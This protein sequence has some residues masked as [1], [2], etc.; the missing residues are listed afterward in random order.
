MTE[1]ESSS[2]ETNK[3]PDEK[4]TSQEK[5]LCNCTSGELLDLPCNNA[6]EELENGSGGDE[7]ESSASTEKSIGDTSE[8]PELNNPSCI[9]AGDFA[10]V[11]NCQLYYSCIPAEPSGDFIRVENKCP[12]RAVFSPILGRC[13]RDISS[14]ADSIECT[15]SGNFP[16]PNSNSSYYWC[17][18][19][20][21]GGFH[22]Y[23]IQCGP[24]EIFLP[25][26]AKCFID[27]M[28]LETFPFN[29]GAPFF[30][31][32]S[33]RDV[34]K[35]EW[36]LIKAQEKAEMKKLQMKEKFEKKLQE[37]I[38]K[39]L[40][41]DAKKQSADEGKQFVC[42]EEGNFPSAI[43]KDRYFVCVSKK[44]KFKAIAMN[45]PM[46]NEYDME[47]KACTLANTSNQSVG[48]KK[49]DDS[50]DDDD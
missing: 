40:L 15:V 48:A 46:G 43:S 8:T 9:Q 13:T 24:S 1:S 19:N 2:T 27:F 16:D 5:C 36:K 3:I 18:E 32:Q 42:V 20:L 50:D 34:V 17:V 44:G 29:F 25:E 39:K 21:L 4:Q 10:D 30:G 38:A 22:K 14:C 45:C 23:H 31:V 49:D 6:T 11:A 12:E 47:R 35:A 26:I 33:D 28:N 37:E 7:M 41:K